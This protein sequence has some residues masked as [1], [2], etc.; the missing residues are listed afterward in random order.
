LTKPV[1]G[2]AAELEAALTDAISE[3]RADDP[4]ISEELAE[5]AATQWATAY[6]SEHY[7][8]T[9]EI[10][11]HLALLGIE[12]EMRSDLAADAYLTRSR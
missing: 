12:D 4:N 6:V 5:E 10:Q 8:L 3:W 9:P 2:T 1:I 7:E 11:E